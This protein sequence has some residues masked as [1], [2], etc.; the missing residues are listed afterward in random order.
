[1]TSMTVLIESRTKASCSSS[2]S[3]WMSQL[4]AKSRT[5]LARRLSP[6]RGAMS[7]LTRPALCRVDSAWSAR[8]RAVS[9]VSKSS[10]MSLIA[11][12]SS[13]V[14]RVYPPGRRAAHG[15]NYPYGDRGGA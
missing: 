10:R 14:V 6:V 1:M 5:L 15:E 11:S 12:P 3:R 8:L 4:S 9:S 2:V 7:S 13:A